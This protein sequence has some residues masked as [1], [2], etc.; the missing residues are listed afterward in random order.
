[1]PTTIPAVV[2]GLASAA[3]AIPKSMMRGP[4]SA[5]ITLLGF[6]SR[7]T[8]PQAWI[9]ASPSASP[10]PSRHTRS[11]PNGPPSA[12]ACCS[13]GPWMNA[14]TIQGGSAPGSASTTDAVWKPPTRRAAS[15]SRAN[16]SRNCLLLA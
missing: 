10:A 3:R 16:R 9:A 1:M 5:K 12:T 7:W 6:R 11:R 14:V 13:E 4:S 15:I 8:S 2:I